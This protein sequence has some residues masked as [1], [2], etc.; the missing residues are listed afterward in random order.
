MNKVF[1]NHFYKFYVR[2][3]NSVTTSTARHEARGTV[4]SER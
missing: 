2:A 1:K 4:Y 3:I